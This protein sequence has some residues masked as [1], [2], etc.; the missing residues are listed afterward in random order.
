MWIGSMHNERAHCVTTDMQGKVLSHSAIIP[1]FSPDNLH[2][3]VVYEGCT[4]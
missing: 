1:L 2:A 4:D 3:Y